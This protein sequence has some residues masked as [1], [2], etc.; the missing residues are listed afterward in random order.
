MHYGISS[1]LCFET[2][3]RSRPGGGSPFP[4]LVPGSH[5]YSDTFRSAFSTFLSLGFDQYSV[6]G[7][8]IPYLVPPGFPAPFLS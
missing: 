5:G 6:P 1:H 7:F 3:P 2:L 8:S 4:S